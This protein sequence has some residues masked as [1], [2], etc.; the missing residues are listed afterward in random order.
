MTFDGAKD[1]AGTT[2]HEARRSPAGLVNGQEYV[3]G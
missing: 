3:A 2:T 1:G